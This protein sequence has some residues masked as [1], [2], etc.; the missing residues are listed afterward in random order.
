[1]EGK[2][3]K[4]LEWGNSRYKFLWNTIRGQDKKN[5]K[6]EKRL[7]T[8]NFTKIARIWKKQHIDHN[9]TNIECY[10]EAIKSRKIKVYKTHLANYKKMVYEQYQTWKKERIKIQ[11]EK[12]KSK[13]ETNYTH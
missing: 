3:I 1:M 10:L 9:S 4:R 11:T 12:K 2:A 13:G 6:N 8:S 5:K 7:G